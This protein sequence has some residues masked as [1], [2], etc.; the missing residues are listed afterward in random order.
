MHPQP[1]HPYQLLAHYPQY[2]CGYHT[3]FPVAPS[4]PPHHPP[5][6]ACSP[7]DPYANASAP[8]LTPNVS[9]STLDPPQSQT[10]SFHHFYDSFY[11]PTSKPS[12]PTLAPA[13]ATPVTPAPF[14]LAPP[15]LA[16]APSVSS[17]TPPTPTAKPHQLYVPHVSTAQIASSSQNAH[18][19]SHPPPQSN[20]YSNTFT[21]D[22]YVSVV[23]SPPSPKLNPQPR[24]V[25]VHIVPL[26]LPKK[27]ASGVSANVH[28]SSTQT[29]DADDA[30]NNDDDPP[31]QPLHRR[32]FRTLFSRS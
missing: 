1:Y 20:T 3:S 16:L 14:S 15:A 26:P 6:Y 21:H 9:S 2:P 8:P 17:L 12:A 22:T 5:Q 30:G 7:V 32:R 24:I 28:S 29:L 27:P 10:P 18:Q 19:Q 4:T 31:V 11:F 13:P 23:P 25:N